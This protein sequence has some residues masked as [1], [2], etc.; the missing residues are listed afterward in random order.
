MISWVLAHFLVL[1]LVWGPV[2]GIAALIASDLQSSSSSATPEVSVCGPIADAVIS[3][4]GAAADAVDAVGGAIADAAAEVRSVRH[5][6]FTSDLDHS[7][8]KISYKCVESY[9]WMTSYSQRWCNFTFVSVW[10]FAEIKSSGGSSR[11]EWCHRRSTNHNL[12]CVFC[13]RQ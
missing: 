12:M 8:M 6:L 2:G 9:C 4:G 3:A 5:H 11:S 10:S 13:P 1:S 7:C